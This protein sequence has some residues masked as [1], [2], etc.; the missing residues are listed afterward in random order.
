MNHLDGG[1][2]RELFL[3]ADI[4]RSKLHI[5]NESISLILH[6]CFGGHASWFKVSCLQNWSFKFSVSS[7]DVGFAIIKSG[8]YVNELFNAGFFLWGH[9]SPDFH[10]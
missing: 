6:S 5:N 3:V 7:K 10:K 9:G 1:N 2:L 8:N 4:Y